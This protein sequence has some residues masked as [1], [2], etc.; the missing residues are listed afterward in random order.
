MRYGFSYEKDIEYRESRDFP[1]FPTVDKESWIEIQFQPTPAEFALL[2][3]EYRLPDG[4]FQ[5]R[6]YF[7]S[8]EIDDEGK[9]KSDIYA[10]RGG[11]LSNWQNSTER[12]MSRKVS[13]VT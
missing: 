1:K 12:K 2:K 7:Q 13:S 8:V 4:T 10:Y 3:E 6:K 9:T 11:A 5:V